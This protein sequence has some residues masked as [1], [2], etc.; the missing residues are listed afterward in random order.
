MNTFN[1]ILTDIKTVPFSPVSAGVQP[2]FC[3]TALRN[4]FDKPIGTLGL[5]R[6]EQI[7]AEKP[8]EKN[9]RNGKVRC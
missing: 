7:M 2:H 4:S 1:K 8:K 6:I 3:H 5:I 9:V